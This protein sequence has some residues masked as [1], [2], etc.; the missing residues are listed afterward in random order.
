LFGHLFEMTKH[1][2]LVHPHET[3]QVLARLLVLKCDLFTDDPTLASSPYTLK[4]RISLDDFREFVSALEGTTATITNNNFK[5]LSQLCEEFRFRDLAAQL[6]DFRNSG[7]FKE[8]ST[9]ED[10][11]ARMRLSAL[12]ER[13][14]D[15]DRE[16][17]Q[18]RCDLL[19]QSRAHESVEKEV[20]AEAES[21]GR[22]AR[23]A[24]NDVGKVRSEVEALCE[25][26]KEMRELAESTRVI[27]LAN[28]GASEE[29]LKKAESTEVLLGR[30]A[31]LET[32]LSTLK[33]TQSAPPAA[34]RIF[35]HS[36]FP[37]QK[38]PLLSTPPPPSGWHSVIVS[39][40]PEIFTEL[41]GK[42]FSLLWRGSRDGFSAHDFHRRCDKHSNTLTLILDA[43]ENIFGGFTPV[44][45]ES[46]EW[47]GDGRNCLKA[48]PSL[49]SFLFTLNNPHNVPA[50][51]FALKPEKKDEAIYCASGRG[52]YFHDIRVSDNCN[53]NSDSGTY[54]FGNR[55]I[56]DTRLDGSTFLTLSTYFQVKEIEVFE[57]TH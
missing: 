17:E 26:L 50:R 14:E 57:I 40:F 56:N 27:A 54:Y 21:A 39:D 7:N 16:I 55:Y 35:R 19:R 29:T 20:R 34:T 2:T 23:E 15:R 5:G 53:T 3:F 9:M 25:T 12:E 36:S 33:A 6:S 48:D 31:R 8:P 43:D 41:H 51:R 1:V 49:T 22:Q 45:W 44:E 46:R 30:V 13:M 37:S 47:Q 38:S 52:P 10:S 4:S 28:Q 42:R 18:L 11:E 24:Q 32:E